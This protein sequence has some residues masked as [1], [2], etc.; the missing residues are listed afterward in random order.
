MKD[1]LFAAILARL[2]EEARAER[3]RTVESVTARRSKD[4]KITCEVRFR[5]APRNI[6]IEGKIE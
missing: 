5:N 2:H 3:N 4:G 6:K 1:L